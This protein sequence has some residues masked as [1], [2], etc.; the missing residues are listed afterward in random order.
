M[1]ATAIS[2]GTDEPKPRD[3]HQRRSILLGIET[4]VSSRRLQRRV[5]PAAA[6]RR[7]QAQHRAGTRTR[8]AW[9]PA[10]RRWCSGVA[11]DD[12]HQHVAAQV[13]GAEPVLHA[14]ALEHAG[15]GHLAQSDAVRQDQGA[16]SRDGDPECEHGETRACRRAGPARQ[17]RYGAC[18]PCAAGG[19]RRAAAQSLVP[20]PRDWRRC[21][22]RR[23]AVT[24]IR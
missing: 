20:Q 18:A 10:P 2:S 22:T 16:T 17:A 21:R 6:D 23:R 24:R 11:V 13:V 4:S 5:E 3:D 19:K 1:A 7:Q 9:P 12:A 14:D 8:A 15:V